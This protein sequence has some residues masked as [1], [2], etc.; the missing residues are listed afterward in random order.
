MHNICSF[1]HSKLQILDIWFLGWGKVS[2]K[3]TFLENEKPEN[4]W[5]IFEQ[6]SGIFSHDIVLVPLLVNSKVVLCQNFKTVKP[7][8]FIYKH[9]SQSVNKR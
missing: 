8:F 5:N 1:G 9:N 3:V 7:L 2:P 6:N 4:L